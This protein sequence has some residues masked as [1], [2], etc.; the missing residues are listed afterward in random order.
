MQSRVWAG[1]CGQRKEVLG[2]DLLSGFDPSL[3]ALVADGP[4]GIKDALRAPRG[5]GF[6]ILDANRPACNHAS[7]DGP[8]PDNRFHKAT[9]LI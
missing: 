5:G 3:A 8:K 6:A 7:S 9:C 1:V 4:A 2:A